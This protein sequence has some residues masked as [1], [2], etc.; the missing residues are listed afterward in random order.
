MP[1]SGS[2]PIDLVGH[3][4]LFGELQGI[5]FQAGE[6]GFR[7]L[8]LGNG[9]DQ[10]LF[11]GNS[12]TTLIASEACTVRVRQA[13]TVPQTV[14][15]AWGTL[16]RTEEIAVLTTRGAPDDPSDYHAVCWL[17]TLS[18]ADGTGTYG[19]TTAVLPREVYTDLPAAIAQANRRGE[20]YRSGF[21]RTPAP[22]SPDAPYFTPGR[23]G[24]LHP[25]ETG[26][27]ILPSGFQPGCGRPVCPNS[28]GTVAL[29]QC[30]FHQD[31]WESGTQWQLDVAKCNSD[32]SGRLATC[33]LTAVLAFW[34][35]P[36][37]AGALAVCAMGAKIAHLSCL[38]S[39]A[40]TA[41]RKHQ[42]NV[43]KYTE[44]IANG[45]VVS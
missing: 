6:H 28:L 14:P 20:A 41:E 36:A 27:G 34:S 13:A 21:Q 23:D 45:T 38:E 2:E 22:C 40:L 19:E 26:P 8:A 11:L 31:E 44:C 1:V 25:S 35:G 43:S 5:A 37:A 3:R 18:G 10:L 15:W 32:Y 4:F 16:T 42:I 24:A 29:C 9:A 7:L 12:G 30:K 39:A 17:I 33:L